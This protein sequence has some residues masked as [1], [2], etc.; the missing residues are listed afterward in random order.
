MINYNNSSIVERIAHQAVMYM[1]LVEDTHYDSNDIYSMNPIYINML[2]ACELYLKCLL[3]K[4]GKTYNE[5]KNLWHHFNKLFN[6]LNEKQKKELRNR[7]DV[8]YN[9]NVDKKVD[10]INDDFVYCRYMFFGEDFNEVKMRFNAVKDLMYE[11][12]HMV[13]MELFNK[14]TYFDNKE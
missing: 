3:L 2:F 7:F 9:L 13:S 11:L 4:N 5:V 10:L 1:K 6:N 12:D 8:F 14:D